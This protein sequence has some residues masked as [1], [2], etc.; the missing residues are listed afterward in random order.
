MSVPGPFYFSERVPFG[1]SDILSVSL[2][3][4]YDREAVKHLFRVA[5]GLDSMLLGEAEILARCGKYRFSRT[6]AAR[7]GPCLN[8]LFQALWRSGSVCARKRSLARGPCQ[9]LLPE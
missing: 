9:W 3:H 8:R 7:R 5:A 1:A 4:H 2:Y 6:S